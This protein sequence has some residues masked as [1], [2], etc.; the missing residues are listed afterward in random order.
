MPFSFTFELLCS[1]LSLFTYSL[2]IILYLMSTVFCIKFKLILLGLL[3][4]LRIENPCKFSVSFT[5][6]PKV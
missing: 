3:Q 4:A 2:Y 1:S 5:E 6:Y